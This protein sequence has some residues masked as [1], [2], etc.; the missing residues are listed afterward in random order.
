MI[1][2]LEGHEDGVNCLAVSSDDS[3]LV[4]GS[5]DNTARVWSIEDV[6]QE[7]DLE[8]IDA[9]FDDDNGKKDPEGDEDNKSSKNT[10]REES[11]EDSG[12]E[13]NPKDEDVEEVLNTNAE[14]DSPDNQKESET[15]LGAR[16]EGKS[17]CLGVLR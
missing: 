6:E 15:N 14:K 2:Q 10:P 8:D 16:N 13:E 5:E 17:R 11:N 12:T 1:Y 3:V 4:S 7:E 9:L